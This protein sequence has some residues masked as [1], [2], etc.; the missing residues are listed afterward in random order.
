[1]ASLNQLI[2]L[3]IRLFCTPYIL[4]TKSHSA[5]RPAM[6]CYKTPKCSFET[7]PGAGECL[8]LNVSPGSVY[9]GGGAGGKDKEEI[10][11]FLC[12]QSELLQSCSRPGEQT[13]HLI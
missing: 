10:M 4:P 3:P 11:E 5:L 9:R 7:W 8:F 12:L 2:C 6:N 13:W 1:M